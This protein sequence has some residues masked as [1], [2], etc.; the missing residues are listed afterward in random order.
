MRIHH[1]V[2]IIL[3]VAI[4]GAI[5][6]AVTVGVLLGSLER[7]ARSA[8]KAAEQYRQVQTVVTGA[9]ELQ[10]TVESLGPESGEAAFT[11]LDQD[12][13][14]AVLDLANLRHSALLDD[15]LPV[16][17]AMLVLETMARQ[18]RRLAERQAAG[19]LQPEEVQQFR[20][21]ISL[22]M[23]RLYGVE[24]DA[25]TAAGDRDRAL[26][27]A[28]KVIMVVIGVICIL[29]LAVIE[30]V[31]H[32]TTRRLIHPVQTLANAAIQAMESE[33]AFR[34]LEQ[35]STEE[36]NTLARVLANFVNTLKARV[37][38]RTAEV[39]KQKEHL[40][41]EV[42]VRRRAEDQLRHAAFH[43]K[44]T[45]L[46]NRDLL[47]DRLERC[48]DR[49]R[50][51]DGYHF[52]VLFLDIDRFKEV[53]DS[54]GHFMGDQLLV[55]IAERLQQC[56]RGTDSLTRVESNTVARIGGDEFVVLLDGIR[57]RADAT[58]VA[59]RVQDVLSEPFRLQGHEI[60]TTASIGIAFNEL[61]CEKADHLLR[62]ADTAMYY[63]KAA[64][65]ARHEVFNTKMHDEAMSRLKLHTDL[66]RAVEANEFHV[67]YQ[68]IISLRTGRLAGFEVLARWDHPDRGA[69]DPVDFISHAEDTGLIVELGRW[70]LDQACWQLRAWKDLGLADDRLTMSVNVSK[71]QVAEPG[72]VEDVQ[73]ILRD[74][75][76]DGSRLA[77]E[78]TESVI[79]ENPD[80]IAE[81]LGQ[82][83][84]LKVEIHMD[85]FGTGYSSLS[86]LHRFPLD[87]LK[88]DRA[89]VST[90]SDDTD[91][92]DIIHTVVALAHTL[93]MQVI[94]EGVETEQQLARLMLLDCDFAQGYHFS[95]P[96][97]AMGAAEI[98][99]ATPKWL[100]PAA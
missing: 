61:E 92:A 67:F 6:L 96:L 17:E 62:D 73:Q 91:Y 94:V 44:L 30:R 93:S 29:Y 70:V 95:E 9:R 59:E 89:F 34:G 64:G 18:G 54:L 99:E 63:A 69:V 1:H 55:A 56:L 38:D 76:M 32:W 83:K 36:L 8:G 87:V 52:A 28:R 82:L 50:R 16:E 25:A 53:N 58:V 98:L 21:G 49:A 5:G 19:I 22:F 4:A 13:E 10:E 14:R 75:R 20:D 51:N 86:Y 97:G 77:L 35:G 43:D 12:F 78:I 33:K 26:A 90:M 79:M 68:P 42:A 2:S 72:F 66:K 47:L 15:P 100:K 37:R 74:H 57:D 48:M 88:I 71:R 45:G 31:R 60:F 27:R 81:V 40:E 85:D 7:A 39:E 84:A 65:K 11:M 46:C 24:R 3:F 23:K 80:S 41:R